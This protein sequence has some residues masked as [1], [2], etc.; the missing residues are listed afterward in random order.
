MKPS[1]RRPRITLAETSGTPSTEHAV[2]RDALGR[3]TPPQRAMLALKL[4]ERLSSAEAALALGMPVRTFDVSYRS[5]LDTLG[6]A[7][8]RRVRGDVAGSFDALRMRRAS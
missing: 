2:I 6:R 8:T 4:V 3:C 1:P 5:L 7:L